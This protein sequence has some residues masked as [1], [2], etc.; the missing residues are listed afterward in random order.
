V[1]EGAVLPFDDMDL[2]VAFF[3]L[4]FYL[5]RITVASAIDG[6]KEVMAS[7]GHL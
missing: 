5:L 4:Q 2:I 3:N 6:N 7:T 1:E